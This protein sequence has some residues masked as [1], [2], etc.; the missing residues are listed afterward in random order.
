MVLRR[1]FV[2]EISEE[3]VSLLLLFV[4]AGT[5]EFAREG[6]VHGGKRLLYGLAGFHYSRPF[7]HQNSHF[8]SDAEQHVWLCDTTTPVRG[9]LN[10][11]RSP[12]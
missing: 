10:L 8:D 11:W 5:R 2:D 1:M 6:S 12:G 9:G 3:L 7:Y 4:L